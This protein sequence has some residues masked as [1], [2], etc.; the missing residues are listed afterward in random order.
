MCCRFAHLLAFLLLM[1]ISGCAP[2]HPGETFFA[3]Y[4]SPDKQSNVSHAFVVKNTTSDPVEIRTVDRNCTCTSFELGKYRLARGEPTTLTINV[5]VLGTF[6]TRTAAC[7]LKTDNPR[8]KDWSYSLTFVSTAFAV[9]DPNVLNLGSFNLDGLN[10]DAVKEV[11]LDLF[12]DSKIELARDDFTVPDEIELNVLSKAEVR[13]LQ[14]DMWKTTYK[15]SIG[16]SA[17]GRQM[18]LRNA[19]AGIVTKTIE[20]TTDGP[21]SRRWQY[22]VY[23]QT[24]ASLQSHPSYL[25]FGNLLDA[26][27]DHRRRVVISSTTGERFRILSVNCPSRDVRIEPTFDAADEVPRQ[28]V[29][30]DVP[31]DSTVEPRL[32]DSSTRFFSGTIQVQTT[33]KF[34]PLVKIPWSAM[35]HRPVNPPSKV[36]QAKLS[37]GPGLD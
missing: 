20:L 23:W 14:R 29:D 6:M 8:F 25:S 11:T 4:I 16:L 10:L 31:R 2:T 26:T 18:A 30:F 17:Q 15:V 1:C 12:A 7:F 9:A 3:G 32:N 37:Q 35:L 36:G 21:K 24:L 19:G 28:T 27:D 13:K 22:S 5:D 33:N 34:Q